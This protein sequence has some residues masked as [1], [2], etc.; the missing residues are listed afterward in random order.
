MAPNSGILPAIIT[1]ARFDHLWL[2]HDAWQS[3]IVHQWTNQK[4]DKARQRAPPWSHNPTFINVPTQSK[5]CYNQNFY[6]LFRVQYQITKSY[7][8]QKDLK[9]RFE[10]YQSGAT[11]YALRGRLLTNMT[12]QHILKWTLP[13]MKLKK[14]AQCPLIFVDQHYLNEAWLIST[15]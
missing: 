11:R 7:A 15:M 3:Q 8:S 1:L 5:W 10:I 2:A 6:N 4:E 9:S 14:I 13:E 12:L